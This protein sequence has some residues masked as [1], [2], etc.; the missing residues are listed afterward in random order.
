MTL[1]LLAVPAAALMTTHTAVAR[2]M[3]TPMR[4]KLPLL[5]SSNLERGN[6][7]NKFQRMLQRIRQSANADN[8]RRS[9][10]FALVA[11][12]R[13]LLPIFIA[14][15]FVILQ[16]SRRGASAPKPVELS[17]A[18][19]MK[20]VEGSRSS[21][22]TEMRVSLSRISFLLD[23]HP[24]FTRPV[25]APSDLI[26]FLHK[27]G[28]DFRA[29]AASAAATILPLLFPCIWLLALYSLMRKQM[30]G[31]TGS[32]GKKAS[33]SLRLSSDN[34]TF[35]DVA[36]IDVAKEEARTQRDRCSRT[37]DLRG[38]PASI[39]IVDVRTRFSCVSFFIVSD[40]DLQMR[41]CQRLPNVCVQVREIVSMLKEP[42]KYA[43]AG[44]R[45]PAGVLMAGPPGTGKT[46]LAR[47][48][49]AQVSMP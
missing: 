39:A 16:V 20:L 41:A 30:G 17:Y 40:A 1:S 38:C 45:L 37:S 32:V 24:T 15:L 13:P 27:A 25:R 47:V 6:D 48:M 22:I 46:L 4:T 43:A 3:R 14:L 49:A 42:S 21:S 28:V 9:R 36:G 11:R 35:E 5:A 7:M 18:A 31:A 10:L 12:L 33:T 26:W 2:P 34:L 8:I 19:F 23:G 29:A 44:A